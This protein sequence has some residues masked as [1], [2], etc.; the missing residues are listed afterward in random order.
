METILLVDVDSARADLICKMLVENEISASR[1]V[2]V[3]EVLQEIESVHRP[4]VIVVHCELVHNAFTQL[5]KLVHHPNVKLIFY[6][7]DAEERS[8]GTVAKLPEELGEI[9]L[10]I[11][12]SARLLKQ[13]S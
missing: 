7:T 3:E 8:P 13:A 12:E 1:C 9:I 6:C 11:M 5:A 10:K 4:A 2:N